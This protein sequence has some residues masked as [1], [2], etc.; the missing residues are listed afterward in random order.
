MPAMRIAELKDGV[1]YSRGSLGRAVDDPDEH[2]FVRCLHAHHSVAANVPSEL[3]DFSL[4]SLMPARGHGALDIAVLDRNPEHGPQQRRSRPEA[5]VPR[6]G[7][8]C[9][10]G[11]WRPIGPKARQRPDLTGTGSTQ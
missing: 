3:S 6:H 11:A 4:G 7:R 2:A 8:L 10:G 9:L 1:E 5:E